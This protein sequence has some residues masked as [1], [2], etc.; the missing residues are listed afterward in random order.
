M[1]QISGKRNSLC[2]AYLSIVLFLKLEVV[3]IET[4]KVRMLMSNDKA[5]PVGLGTSFGPVPKPA[6]SLKGNNLTVARAPLTHQIK[7]EW[8][9]IF[10]S[11]ERLRVFPRHGFR[12]HLGRDGTRAHH[13]DAQFRLLYLVSP[14]LDQ[15]FKGRF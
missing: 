10:W 12:P 14:G 6:L 3:A 8:R 7:E 15:G 13:I 4:T 9:N 5:C 11:S 2:S 1:D